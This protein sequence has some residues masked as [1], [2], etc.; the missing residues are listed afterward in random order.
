MSSTSITAPS[1]SRAERA[2]S[3]LTIRSC[4]GVADISRSQLIVRKLLG[5]AAG[6]DCHRAVRLLE[7]DPGFEARAPTDTHCAPRDLGVKLIAA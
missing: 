3:S 7:A 6:D 2:G 4:S 1:R 5:K